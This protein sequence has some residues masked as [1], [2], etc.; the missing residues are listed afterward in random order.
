MELR[1]AGLYLTTASAHLQTRQAAVE[2]A[3]TAYCVLAYDAVRLL[4]ERGRRAVRLMDGMPEWRPAEL[5][6]DTESAA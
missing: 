1:A 5:P 4:R 2:P 6:V 3:R